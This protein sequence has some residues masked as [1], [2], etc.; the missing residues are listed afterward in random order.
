MF[1]NNHLP[2]KS[3]E[4]CKYCDNLE[5]WYIGKH[6]KKHLRD[7]RNASRRTALKKQGLQFKK[8]TPSMV[9]II[10]IEAYYWNV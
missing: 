10:E 6:P 1:A 2:A 9:R 5:N 8:R 7:I 4:N 3:W